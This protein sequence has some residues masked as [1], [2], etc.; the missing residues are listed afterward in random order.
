MRSRRPI[1]PAAR[2]LP[3][4]TLSRPLSRAAVPASGVHYTHT[5]LAR[6]ASDYAL[7]GPPVRV[8]LLSGAMPNLG[9]ASGGRQQLRAGS[10][11][12]E[13]TVRLRIRAVLHAAVAER[14]EA[15]VLGAYGCG[16]FG[17]PPALVARIF[18]QVL[19]SAEFRGQL[20]LVV[21]AIVDPKPSD[22]GNL[23]AFSRELERLCAP[24]P[25]G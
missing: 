11:A 14:H 17:N 7:A 16:A 12:W 25:Q 10:D 18:A 9:S 2:P 22:D 15:V 21:F 13:E 4:P 24:P 5:L 3:P 1:A 6:R 8:A 20:R 19:R 23:H